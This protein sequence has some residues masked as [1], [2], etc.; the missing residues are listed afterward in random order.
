MAG[1]S[2][3]GGA[4]TAYKGHQAQQD[5]FTPYD[6]NQ[7]EQNQQPL[8]DN[9]E[10]LYRSGGELQQRGTDTFNQGQQY[11]DVGS[12]VNQDQRQ[13]IMGNSMD[14]LALQNT[15]GQRGPNVNTGMFAQQ[16]MANA[17]NSTAQANQQF[18]GQMNQNRSFGQGMMNMGNSMYTGGM[19][20]Q[21]GST[22][23][24]TGL[25]DNINQANISN[26]EM[27]NNK[28]AANANYYGGLSNSLFSMAGMYQPGAPA[29][30]PPVTPPGG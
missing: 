23:Q 5:A 26:T 25:V 9:Y 14:M 18:L 29:A 21:M 22:N 19:N 3:L 28:A 6:V 16:Q 17:Q 30:T 12:Q 8:M 20:T 1:A 4:Y 7:I 15:M 2:L 27:G 13:N 10:G 11:L 24:M